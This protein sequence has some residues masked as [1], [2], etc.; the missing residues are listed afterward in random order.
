M[1]EK[2]GNEGGKVKKKEIK[3]GALNKD[4]SA[5][6]AIDDCIFLLTKPVFLVELRGE[7]GHGAGFDGLELGLDHRQQRNVVMDSRLRVLS[8]LK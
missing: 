8:R 1:G 6:L 7:R 5:V 4:R 2:K 3:E